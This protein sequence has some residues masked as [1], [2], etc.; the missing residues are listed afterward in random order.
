METLKR[1]DGLLFFPEGTRS[2]T[3]LM[4]PFKIGVAVMAIED[5]APVIPTRIDHAYDLFPKGQRWV[6]PG[7]V[8]VTFGEPV[9]PDPW[10]RTGSIEEQYEQYRE[11]ARYVQS[12]IASLGAGCQ[13]AEVG[14]SP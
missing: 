6:R 3:G 9:A 14:T 12:Q 4:Q 1:G 5:N 7:V 10:R 8:R 11:L 2:L 13:A